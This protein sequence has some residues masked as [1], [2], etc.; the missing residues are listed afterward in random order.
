MTFGNLDWRSVGSLGWSSIYADEND[1]GP[2]DAN[3]AQEGL[4]ILYDPSQK[5]RGRVTPAQIV[6]IAPTVLS[7]MG[8]PVPGDMI[9]KA[10]E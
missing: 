8:L 4:F 1:T 10:I 2:D 3:H 5:G 7:L 9:G 6:D